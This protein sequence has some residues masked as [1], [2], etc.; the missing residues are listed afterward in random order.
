VK[1]GT[2]RE[3]LRK[4]RREEKKEDSVF[5]LCLRLNFEPDSV[6]RAVLASEAGR[7]ILNCTRQ[8][9]KSTVS[10]VKAVHR[11][12]SRAGSLVLVASP[13]ERQSGELVRKA[14][15]F[16]RRLGM[17]ARGDGDNSISVAFPNGSRIVGLPGTPTTVRG[18]SAVSLLL[19]DEASRVDDA[20]YKTLRPVLA[21][22]GGDMWMMSTPNG[23]RGFFYEEWTGSAGWERFCVAATECPRIP[24]EFLQEERTALGSDWYGQE[25]MCEFVDNGTTLFQREMVEAALS[26]DLA[27]RF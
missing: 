5:A 19:I 17:P 10:A 9:G 16:T 1:R 18:F 22:S 4:R 24:A 7:G 23:K 3:V 11:A 14:A 12:W 27:L 6:Q 21:V 13:T 26:D 20:L 8:W 15:E 25:Y 2:F